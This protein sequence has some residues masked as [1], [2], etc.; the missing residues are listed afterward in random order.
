[1][2]SIES[3]SKA[4]IVPSGQIYRQLFDA[5][6]QLS[7]SLTFYENGTQSLKSLELPSIGGL[8]SLPV[9]HLDREPTQHGI[10]TSRQ[11]SWVKGSPNDPYT[12][13]PV[14]Y[15]QYSEY[16]QQK[17]STSE[18]L[19]SEQEVRGLPDIIVPQKNGSNIIQRIAEGRKQR[20]EAAVED[21]HQ[22]LCLINSELEPLIEVESS[23]LLKKMDDDNTVIEG[24]LLTLQDDKNLLKMSLSS[25][26]NLWTDILSHS[27]KRQNWILEM[28][29]SLKNIETERMN[30][31]KSVFNHFGDKFHKISHLA[32]SDLQ[33]FLDKET[34]MINQTVLSNQRSFA[35]LFVR[36]MS[37]DVE[38]EKAHRIFW[39]MRVEDWKAAHIKITIENFKNF[40]MTD[41]VTQPASIS[42]VI[43]NFKLD[44]EQLRVQCEALVESLSEMKPP[45]A[46]KSAVY[47]WRNDAN[48]VIIELDSVNQLY[49]SKLYEEYEKVC[50]SCLEKI[51]SEKEHMIESGICS[52]HR[53]RQV[54]DEFMLP[55]VGQQQ[56][57]FE[58]EIESLEKQIEAHKS[59]LEEQV[60]VLFKFSQ[61]AAHL[62]DVHEIGL[63]KQERALQ[64]KLEECRHKHDQS[65]QEKEAN[66]DLVM[67]RMRQ[68]A[69][70]VALKDSLIK[71]HNMLEKIRESYL[72]FHQ[73]QTDIVQ[74]YP[75]MINAELNTYEK[76]ICKFFSVTKAKERIIEM[77]EEQLDESEEKS[78]IE[79]KEE[80]EP[81]N[82]EKP[83][84][85]M[86]IS[87][88]ES[89]VSVS[90]MICFFTDNCVN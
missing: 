74:S 63:A 73:Q 67:D 77:K 80:V 25:L 43:T 48:K 30:K 51:N 40:M 59:Q 32:R 52:E 5:Q 60:N 2:S 41:A 62:W 28:D 16:L 31:I 22:E 54:M 78:E 11:K 88:E 85:D 71:A 6:L 10:L 79:D 33:R 15:K 39:Q 53:A 87:S 9:F 1:M 21:L 89:F 23:E 3:T 26:E 20:H 90:R 13:N 86:K 17:L 45:A 65:N 38:R 84:D 4:R 24:I 14:L 12:E 37:A 75:N 29:E 19:K 50:Q 36:L 83:M 49:L 69:N 58:L 7:K 81:E 82:Q 56:R 35:D 68:D 76:G 27:E 42:Q 70:D 8:T 72:E 61:G 34:Q 66:L 55:L 18:A 46:T 57:S 47:Q 44:Q 64:E